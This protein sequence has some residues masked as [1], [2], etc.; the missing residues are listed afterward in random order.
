[1]LV[2]KQLEEQKDES[3]L[4]EVN[5]RS[6]GGYLSFLRLIDFTT[7]LYLAIVTTLILLFHH[8]VEKWYLFVFANLTGMGLL[9]Y[10]LHQTQNSTSRVIRVLREI[11]PLLLFTFLFKETAL[12]INIFFPFWF[13]HHLIRWEIILFGDYPIHDLRQFESPALTEFMAFSYWSYYLAM[14]AGIILLYLR[15]NLKLLQSFIFNLSLT[16][17]ICYLSYLFLTAR[18]P[19]ETLPFLLDEQG[20]FGLFYTMVLQIQAGAAISGAAFPSSHVTAVWI[21]LIYMFRSRKL[22]GFLFTPLILSLTVSTVYLNYHYAIDAIAGILLVCVTYP[23]GI[24]VEKKF[25]LHRNPLPSY[26]PYLT[27]E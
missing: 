14:P 16:M 17:Y 27:P 26:S 3:P 18:G 9:F 4:T 23:L 19:R 6:N 2:E 8:N 21:V 11:Y 24:F 13:E 20:P 25:N 5:S 22:L 12:I 1:M 7:L 15:R 10:A